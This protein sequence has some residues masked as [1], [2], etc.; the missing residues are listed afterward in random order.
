MK[1]KSISDKRLLVESSVNGKKACFLVD[2]GATVG[3]LDDTQIR[4]YG[5]AKGSKFN[6]SLVGQGGAFDAPYRCNTPVIAPN[7]KQMTQF[8]LSDIR[9]VRESI[10]QETGKTI[11]GIIGLPQ[12][13]MANVLI[14]VINNEIHF[15]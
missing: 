6:G 8:L 3:L 9:S 2:T 1:V 10:E 15:H 14:D 4:Q 12:M 11:L 13:R 7:G 5:L